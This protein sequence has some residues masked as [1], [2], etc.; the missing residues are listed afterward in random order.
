MIYPYVLAVLGTVLEHL[1]KSGIVGK[2]DLPFFDK[3][4]EHF[5][6]GVSFL[7]KIKEG[8]RAHFEKAVSKITGVMKDTA[9]LKKVEDDADKKVDDAVGKT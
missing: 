4:K 7:T 6:N 1:N 3:L 2:R 9:S 5:A 8:L